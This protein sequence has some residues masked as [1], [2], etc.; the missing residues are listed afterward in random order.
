MVSL[1]ASFPSTFGEEIGTGSTNYNDKE[2]ISPPNEKSNYLQ[3]F[4]K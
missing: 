3:I 2:F 4:E 1:H